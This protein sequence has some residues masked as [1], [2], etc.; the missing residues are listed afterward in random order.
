M[1]HIAIYYTYTWCIHNAQINFSTKTRKKVHINICLQTL[2][3]QSTNPIFTWPH[4]FWLLSVETLKTLVYSG[5][6]ENGQI[7]YQRIFVPVRPFATAPPLNGCQRS[8]S[9]MTKHG[10]TQVQDFWAFI[11]K[12]DLMHHKNWTVIKWLYG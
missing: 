11:V 6:L 7:L 8:W 9:D 5:P 2:S 3:S 1:Q 12:C 4:S 10:F